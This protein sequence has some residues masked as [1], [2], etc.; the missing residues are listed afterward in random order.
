MGEH[1]VV[2]G[3]QAVALAI[4]RRFACSVERSSEDI[5]NGRPADFSKH[6]YIHHML[7]KYGVNNISVDTVSDIPAGS[8]LGSSAALSVSISAAIR[9]MNGTTFNE[10]E[11][12]M[13]AF[14]TEYEV[15]G[16]ASPA[17]T[18]ASVHGHGISVNGPGRELWNVSRGGNDW[19]ISEIDIPEL[20]I[21]VG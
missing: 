21:V 2:Y 15:Q 6:P 19:R 5:L 10:R 9:S 18:S 4:D 16:R 13:D 20:T 11:I 3:K 14:D 8:G 7:R 1:A 17:D 12:A